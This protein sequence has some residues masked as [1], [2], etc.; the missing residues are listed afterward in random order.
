MQ[1]FKEIRIVWE[2]FSVLLLFLLLSV[3]FIDS[4]SLLSF[5]PK[6]TSISLNNKQCFL[7]GTTRA[8]IEVKNFNFN[9]AYILNKFSIYLFSIL[10]FNSLIFIH[11]FKKK[12]T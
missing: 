2:I 11:L 7:C 1:I 3:F 9:N 10:L 12:F 6:C 8:F 4:H 5:S